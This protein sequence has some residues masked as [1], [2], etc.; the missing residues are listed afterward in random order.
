[1]KN[2]TPL[3]AEVTDC[4]SVS[5]LKLDDGHEVKINVSVEVLANRFRDYQIA[6]PETFAQRT[7]EVYFNPVR[8]TAREWSEISALLQEDPVAINGLRRS[9]QIPLALKLPFE[10]I[11][12]M[13]YRVYAGLSSREYPRLYLSHPYDF[14]PKGNEHYC[15]LNDPEMLYKT[16]VNLSKRTV[17]IESGDAGRHYLK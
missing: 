12:S 10:Q 2:G 15:Q 11:V 7:V 4:G 5:I 13:P 14:Y 8:M 3:L 1:M 16:W 6:V 17:R 9:E